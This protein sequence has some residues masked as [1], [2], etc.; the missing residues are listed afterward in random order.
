[1]TK[2]GGDRPTP[3]HDTLS[4]TLDYPHKHPMTFTFTIPL[5]LLYGAAGAV[6]TVVVA[7]VIYIGLAIFIVSQLR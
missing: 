1:M 7:G 3:C 4:R 2:Y 6:G 5:W